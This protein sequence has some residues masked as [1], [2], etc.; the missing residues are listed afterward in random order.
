MDIIAQ[1]TIVIAFIGLIALMAGFTRRDR[2]YGP[3][4]MWG[5]VMCM[6][7]VI[8]YHIVRTLQ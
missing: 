1:T 4:L 7:G 5:G 3:F 6:L 2:N 8:V